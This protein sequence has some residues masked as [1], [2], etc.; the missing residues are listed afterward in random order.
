MDDVAVVADAIARHAVTLLVAASLVGL[1]V[2]RVA[3]HAI[4]RYAP[5]IRPV[6]SR[7]WQR[8]DR[9][10]HVARLLGLEGAVAF[11]LAAAATFGFVQ[12]VDAL[13]EEEELTHFD[14]ALAEAFG[15]HLSDGTLAFFARV[16]HLGDFEV[17]TVFGI[18]LTGV[19]LLRRE[20]LLAVG[21]AVA[22]LGTAALNE[23]LKLVFSR[24]RPQFLHGLVEVHGYSFPSGHAAGS[25]AFYGFAAYLAARCLPR[26]WHLPS[27]GIALL[28]VVFVGTSRVLL[29][30]HYASDV[31]AGW[32]G[33]ATWTALCIMALESVR[34]RRANG[35]TNAN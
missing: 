6:A 23:G 26:R 14:V 31:L 5:A 9:R 13:D 25:F 33:A 11:V 3:W 28:L 32:L 27:A 7:W 24:A 15:R 35:R 17:L 2:A 30:V 12:L 20:W 18:V 1:V 16:T 4:A 8:I 21:L 19:L 10:Q 29:Q 34:V 22:A